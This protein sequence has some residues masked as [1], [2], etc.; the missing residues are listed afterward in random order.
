MVLNALAKPLLLGIYENDCLIQ[1]FESEEKASEFVPKILDQI[2]KTHEIE[3]L[4]YANG[5]GSYMGIK[6]SYIVFK[7]LSI[8]KNIPL[9]AVS[10]FEFNDFKPISANKNLCFVYKNGEIFLEKN[11]PKP[12]FLPQNLKELNLNNDNLPF[13]FLDAI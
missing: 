10:A 12:F 2:L 5:P 4:V 7:T 13:Y 9:Y 11:E 6:I 8:V 3:R 1:S